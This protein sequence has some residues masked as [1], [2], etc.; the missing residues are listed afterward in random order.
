MPLQP[1]V[2]RVTVKV[3]TADGKDN[4]VAPAFVEIDRG[5]G[6]VRESGADIVVNK[7]EMT[8]DLHPGQRLVIEGYTPEAIVYDRE[9]AAA[10]RPDQQ[11]NDEGKADPA[12]PSGGADPKKNEQT[13]ASGAKPSETQ[14]SRIKSSPGTTVTPAMAATPGANTGAP[15]STPTGAQTRDQVNLGVGSTPPKKEEEKK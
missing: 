13:S 11:K 1:D 9:Q 8:F 5:A 3:T 14:D 6:P 2:R 7:G 4:R 10:I 15:A 12:Q